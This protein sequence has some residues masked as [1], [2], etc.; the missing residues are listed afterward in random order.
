MTFS[1]ASSLVVERF[2]ASNASV[3]SS[4]SLESD[5]AS[6]LSPLSSLESADVAS[7]SASV[8]APRGRRPSATACSSLAGS[9]HSRA[10]S[11]N[12]SR[13]SFVVGR[14]T[15]SNNGAMRGFQHLSVYEEGN[16]KGNENA[17]PLFGSIPCLP[18][19][20]PV[21]SRQP[22]HFV[23]WFPSTSDRRTSLGDCRK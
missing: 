4:A 1:P 21:C 17:Y 7:C 3:T 19:T 15:I 22:L 16:V 5:P 13:C 11:L 2:S 23:E 10:K 8:S 9:A 12:A 18:L 14:G 20:L 6:L